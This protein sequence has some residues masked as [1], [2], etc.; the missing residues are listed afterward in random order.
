M[1]R[2]RFRDSNSAKGGST[3]RLDCL[4]LSSV[5]RCT[6]EASRELGEVEEDAL[7]SV[8]G[9]QVGTSGTADATAGTDAL[10]EGTVLLSVIAVGAEGGVAG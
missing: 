9:A 1:S 3:A 8:D 10:L 7:G 6:L 2:N 5:E 4:D